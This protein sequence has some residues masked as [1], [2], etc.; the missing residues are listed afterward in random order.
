MHD[1]LFNQ[2]VEHFGG[3]LGG[4]GVLMNQVNPLADIHGGLLFGCKL[5]LYALDLRQQLCL[6]GLVLPG[7]RIEVVLR[8]AF[9]RPVLIELCK[10]PVKLFLPFLRP[11]QF[12]L[13]RPRCALLLP[14]VGVKQLAFQYILADV[15]LL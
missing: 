14:V 12:R 5:G 7:Q 2:C 1:D 13:P 4:M 9:R 6:L 10:Q 8:Y 15:R 11:V 3:Q